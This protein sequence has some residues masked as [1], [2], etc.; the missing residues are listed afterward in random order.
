MTQLTEFET[1]YVMACANMQNLHDE[2]NIASDA[3]LELGRTKSE[4]LSGFEW[5]EYDRDALKTIFDQ[6]GSDWEQQ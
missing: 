6:S 1:G 5:S 2:P 4:I 3:L